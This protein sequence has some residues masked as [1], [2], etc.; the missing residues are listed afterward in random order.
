[1]L[2]IIDKYGS[3]L[4]K[5]GE[6]FVTINKH[7][8]SDAS[9]RMEFSADKVSRILI[10]KGAAITTDAIDLAVKRGIG[11]IYLDRMGKPIARTYPCHF[12]DSASIWRKQMKAYDNGLGINLACKIIEAKIKNQSLLIKKLA[13]RRDDNTLK[14][15]AQ[16]ILGSIDKIYG[17]DDIGIQRSALMGIEGEA[18]KQ[19]FSALRFVLP[20]DMYYGKRTKQPPKDLFNALLSYGYGILYTEVERACLLSGLNPYLGFLHSDR[21]GRPSLVMDLIEEF[22]QPVVDST[23][24][25]LITKKVVNLDDIEASNGG[26]Y[27]NSSGK[28]KLIKAIT[29]KLSKIIEYDNRNHSFSSLILLQGKEVLKYI[30]QDIKEYS[31]FI[32]GG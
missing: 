3:Y 14:H 10:Y 23:V 16:T 15:I 6:R 19:Y 8:N 11:I 9:C 13:K 22:R 25:S 2:L 26:F 17:S 28:H 1:M 18:S 20:E 31:P 30:N 12:D 24:I 32:Y 27:L 7:D 29:A 4:H 21:K 5:K